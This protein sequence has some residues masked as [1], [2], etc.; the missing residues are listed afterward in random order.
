[1]GAEK[2]SQDIQGL[3]AIAVNVDLNLDDMG[4]HWKIYKGE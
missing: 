1:M 2:G 3:G 4:N